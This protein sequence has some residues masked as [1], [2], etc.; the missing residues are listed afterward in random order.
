VTEA[1]ARVR[2]PTERRLGVPFWYS[3]RCLEVRVGYLHPMHYTH[4]DWAELVVEVHAAGPGA[5]VHQPHRRRPRPDTP[6][7]FPAQLPAASTLKSLE[8]SQHDT[9]RCLLGG[10]GG[11]HTGDWVQRERE[12]LRM[13]TEAPGF[14]PG[15]CDREGERR[16]CVYK[17]APDFRP[18]PCGRGRE[19]GASACI[20]RH[21]AVAVAPAGDWVCA[22]QA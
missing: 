13:Y 17:Q 10:S 1:N 16:F 4:P 12:T 6:Y 2:M 9:S 22:L 14:S 8:M 5:G 18:C 3:G 20:R 11:S 15:P 21:Q 19:R 7:L